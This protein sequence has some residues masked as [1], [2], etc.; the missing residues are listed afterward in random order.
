MWGVAQYNNYSCVCSD[1]KSR[2]SFDGPYYYNM[3]SS[4]VQLYF[5]SDGESE[6]N[7]SDSS[8]LKSSRVDSQSSETDLEGLP[9]EEGK[10]ETKKKKNRQHKKKQWATI[11]RDLNLRVMSK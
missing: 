10:G 7:M 6:M 9:G 8:H 1:G 5:F 4:S 11:L 3:G 2:P